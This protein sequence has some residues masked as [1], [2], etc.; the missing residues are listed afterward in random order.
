[1]NLTNL[2]KEKDLICSI[3]EGVKMQIPAID[4]NADTYY[5]CSE[6]SSRI[7]PYDFN[8]IVELRNELEK[9]WKDNETMKKL[10]PV[11]LA[12]VFKLRPSDDAVAHVNNEQDGSKN[13]GIL[14]VYTYT[15]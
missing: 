3:S 7:C 6:L 5:I 2:Q 8:T 11:V 14:P 10:I 4:K 9:L 1:M 13:S 12:S 15:L